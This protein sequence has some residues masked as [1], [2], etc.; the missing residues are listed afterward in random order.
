M[1]ISFLYNF[2]VILSQDMYVG[3]ISRKRRVEKNF[4]IM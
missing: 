2:T 4:E 1:Q 3:M